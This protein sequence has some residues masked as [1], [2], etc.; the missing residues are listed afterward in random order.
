MTQ[1]YKFT[2]FQI[3]AGYPDDVFW[4]QFGALWQ[5]S[6]DRSPFKSP[7]IMQDFARLSGEKVRAVQYYKNGELKGAVLLKLE[8]NN[9]SFLSDLKS[10]ANFFVFDQD[11][12]K[13]DWKWF[14]E[15]LLQKAAEENWTLTLNNQPHWAQYMETFEKV[16]KA[17]GMFWQNFAYSVCPIAEYETPEALF[18][19][20]HKSGKLRYYV[21]RL[22]TQEKAVFEALT[23]D[24]DMEQWV[25]EFCNCH[26][27][28]WAGTPTPSGYQT[29]ASRK[30]LT[31][32]LR[33]WSADNLLVRFSIR[34]PGRRIGFIIGLRQEKSLILHSTTYHPDYK[35]HSPGKALIHFMAE[36]MSKNNFSIL[37][38]GDGNEAY[39]Y[40]VANKEKQLNR[41]FTAGK[42]NLGFIARARFIKS[43]KGKNRVY[44]IYQKK[45]KPALRN[46]KRKIAQYHLPFPM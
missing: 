41:I 21:N 29:E 37:D 25:E 13:E 31:K 42:W 30:F 12:T 19:D 39:K 28:R 14:F 3:S 2:H 8:R 17:S 34:V 11:C 4:E 24:S 22:I 46:F 33:A 27:D 6:Q 26:V 43:I 7:H 18:Q 36:W 1:T 44:E 20:V 15:H 16:G 23:D 5:N 10:D 35:K 9:L 45:I 32:C 40:T 38:F